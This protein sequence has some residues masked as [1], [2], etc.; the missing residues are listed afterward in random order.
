VTHMRR[1]GVLLAFTL[2]SLGFATAVGAQT[3]PEYLTVSSQKAYQSLTDR[4]LSVTLQVGASAFTGADVPLPFTFDYL[5]LESDTIRL[6]TAGFISFDPDSA[7]LTR[8]LFSTFQNGLPRT[9][10]SDPDYIIA[11]FWSSSFDNG[12]ISTAVEGTS[13]NR[14]FYVEFED[15]T[16]FNPL[17]PADE[18]S[19]TIALFEADDS[20]E[21]SYGGDISPPSFGT[22]SGV[23]GYEGDGTASG[24]FGTYASCTNTDSCRD[25]DF[26]FVADT[27]FRTLALIEPELSVSAIRLGAS[28][29]PGETTTATVTLRNRGLTT[30]IDVDLEVYASSNGA[31][32]PGG[33]ELLGA[34]ADVADVP[35]GETDVGVQLTL[36]NDLP[37]DEE[38]F[39]IAIVDPSDDIA[40]EIEGDNIEVTELPVLLTGFDL[41]VTSCRLLSGPSPIL[42]GSALTYEVG[43]RNRG[44]PVTASI[45]VALWASRNNSLDRD[46]D[47]SLGSPQTGPLPNMNEYSLQ[48]TGTLP[49]QLIPPGSYF[50]ICDAD[51]MDV[52]AEIPGF[53]QNL[54][55]APPQ[56]RYFIAAPPLV[57]T[58]DALP[59]GR[60]GVPYDHLVG[61]EGGSSPERTDFDFDVEGLPAGLSAD[62]LGRIT[63]IPAVP[64]T[65][66]IQVSISNQ[67]EAA[68]TTFD[69]VIDEAEPLTITD[70]MLESFDLGQ[71]IDRRLETMGGIG[72][73]GFELFGGEL[74]PDLTLSSAGRLV[75]RFVEAGSYQAVIRAFDSPLPG[76]SEDSAT[77]ELDFEV[78]DSEFRIVTSELPQ[79]I[80]GQPYQATIEATGGIE[81]VEFR[82]TSGTLP[83]GLNLSVANGNGR[84]SGTPNSAQLANFRVL[85]VDDV[86]RTRSV[87]LEL[88]ILAAQ[89]SCPSEF[90]PRCEDTSGPMTPGNGAGDEGGGCT[91]AGAPTLWPLIGLALGLVFRRRRES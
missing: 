51:S 82:V 56:D 16:P 32:N 74:P 20:F 80:A 28:A 73:I 64:G 50:P 24:V 49:D 41:E 27:S 69:L 54:A 29:L 57:F 23:M 90:D 87:D 18:G 12:P 17:T 39:L 58:D 1:A 3:E 85:A 63:G 5:G 35:R 26:D 88:R 83:S 70:P 33:D 72:D 79:A 55:V 43:I 37:V 6:N 62:E 78:G 71:S 4:G 66:E 9:G 47:I 61:F 91:A 2:T 31:F 77:F 52:V 7:S 13:P 38:F 10:G 34:F 81:P 46:D 11:P 15:F 14:T 48:V 67:A 89:P 76:G 36:P 8:D 22:V 45:D 42:P 75:G 53:D 40:E 44:I 21:V 30:A 65:F 25:M 19:F 84:I 86:E 60:V 59:T 68:M